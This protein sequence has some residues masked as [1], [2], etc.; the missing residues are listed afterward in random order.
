MDDGGEEGGFEEPEEEGRLQCT[1]QPRG[2]GDFWYLYQILEW[3]MRL[4]EEFEN[5]ES[6]W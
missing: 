2:A 1:W 4:R 6:H 3:K 5:E